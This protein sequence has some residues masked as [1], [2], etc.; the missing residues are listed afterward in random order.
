MNYITPWNKAVCEEI[1]PEKPYV[2]LNYSSI[3]FLVQDLPTLWVY[4]TIS[5]V[6]HQLETMVNIAVRSLWSILSV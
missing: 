3:E 1:V 6:F 2:L 5:A 4:W